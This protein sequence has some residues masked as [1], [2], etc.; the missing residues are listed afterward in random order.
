VERST[1]LSGAL[2]RWLRS[3]RRAAV[4]TQELL[5]ARLQRLETPTVQQGGIFG[6]GPT[7]VPH[8]AADS[9]TSA[10]RERLAVVEAEVKHVR[11][12][13]Q[14]EGIDMA[15]IQF[16]SLVGTADWVQVAN[17]PTMYLDIV[18]LLRV[19]Y[20]HSSDG[21]PQLADEKSAAQVG[22]ASVLDAGIS[23]S[24]KL[25]LPSVF[26][27][28]L[29]V[30]MTVSL[31]ILPGLAS[32]PVWDTK[33]ASSGIRQVVLRSQ[34]L[35]TSPKDPSVEL[36]ARLLSAEAVVAVVEEAAVAMS[37]MGYPRRRSADGWS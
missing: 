5:E 14:S 16:V 20:L 2:I 13:M 1:R 7:A 34:D 17:V 36:I 11:S 22:Y 28:K 24:Y 27:G 37:R 31:K 32:F 29:T 6:L 35:A 21:R 23:T 12:E 15:G 4:C 9:E 18:S 8:P 19:A 33:S 26:A 25:V 10:L 30:T 3:L